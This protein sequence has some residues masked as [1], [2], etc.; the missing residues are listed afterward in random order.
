[1]GAARRG[2][3]VTEGR[4]YRG[5]LTL[6]FQRP[7]RPPHREKARERT[8]A[9]PRPAMLRTAASRLTSRLVGAGGS[10]AATDLACCS[11]AGGAARGYA[12]EPTKNGAKKKEGDRGCQRANRHC[13]RPRPRLAWLRAQPERVRV[14][15][16]TSARRACKAGLAGPARAPRGRVGATPPPR[17]RHALA[18]SLSL[19]PRPAPQPTHPH[20]HPQTAP[21]S[22]LTP[23]P[24]G[25]R[26]RT[27]R[28]VRKRRRKRR[29]APK[30][31]TL[32]PFAPQP[33]NLLSL[34]LRPFPPPRHSAQSWTTPPRPC[35]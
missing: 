13:A 18:P 16:S 34:S 27:W 25:R 8:R 32:R 6:R 17:L 30:K 22:S 15:A 5:P 12:T 31:K 29:G 23:T 11:G 28:Q 1:M 35:S 3:A 26:P 7:R 19:T 2:G 20:S 14:L 24:S 21:R 10:L 9:S 33:L 4:A